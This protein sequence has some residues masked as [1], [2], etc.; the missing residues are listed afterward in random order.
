M[1]VKTKAHLEG[2]VVPAPFKHQGQMCTFPPSSYD[3]RISCN[4]CV[5]D[6]AARRKLGRKR[7]RKVTQLKIQWSEEKDVMRRGDLMLQIAALLPET[8]ELE[9]VAYTKQFIIKTANNL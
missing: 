3:L 9:I 5:G 8:A 7:Q 4:L 6:N 2:Q 1:C